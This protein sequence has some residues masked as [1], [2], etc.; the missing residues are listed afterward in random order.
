MVRNTGDSDTKDTNEDG[1]FDRKNCQMSDSPGSG[2]GGGGGCD[3][4]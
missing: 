3:S 1:D 2:P 4:H